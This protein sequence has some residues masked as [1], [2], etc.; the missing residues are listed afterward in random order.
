M[1]ETRDPGRE[2]AARLR[3]LRKE[4][5]PD[6]A[7]TQPQLAAALGVSAPLISSWESRTGPTIPPE[8]RIASYA[9]LFATP[10]SVDG[11]RIRLVADLTDVEE[12]AR[13]ELERELHALRNAAVVGVRPTTVINEPPSAGLWHFPDGAPVTILCG[14]LPRNLRA[15]EAYS[16]PGSPDYVE[17]Y[18]F[19][20]LDS[21]IELHGHIRAANPDSQVNFHRASF[22]TRDHLTTHLVILGGVD[23][24]E[25]AGEIIE[26]LG[27]PVAQERRAEEDQ[28][29]AFVVATGSKK[30]TFRPTLRVAGGSQTLVEDVAL[31]CRGRN[32]Y[33][34]RRTVTI[35]NG[36]YGRGT[37]GVVRALTDQRFRDRNARYVR[38]HFVQDQT[39]GILTRVKMVR[40]EVITPDWTEPA[41]ILHKWSAAE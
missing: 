34:Q 28:E 41:N 6:T 20:D 9:R 3:R 19:A 38:S 1:E 26:V 16:N 30:Q 40:G 27:V 25:L 21:L 22:I 7:L 2:L 32:P 12:R 37:Y 33:N 36:Q 23:W 35:C 11:D 29:G 8:D 24:N 39:F 31:F 14:T 18:S 4:T 15:D 17:L 5:W 13:V 10:R